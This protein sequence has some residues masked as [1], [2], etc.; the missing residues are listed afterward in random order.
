MQITMMGSQGSL[1][2][3]PGQISSVLAQTGWEAAVRNALPNDLLT[4]PP[5]GRS[6]P[7]PR[8]RDSCPL[9]P[10]NTQQAPN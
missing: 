1:P 9:L 7:G 2:W 4:H 8:G 5:P 10:T 6:S 3:D